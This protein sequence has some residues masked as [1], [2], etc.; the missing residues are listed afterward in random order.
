MADVIG[1]L[2]E[3]HL[4]ACLRTTPDPVALAERLFAWELDG[5]WDV[6]DQA[7]LRYAEVLGDTGLARYRGLAEEAW[8]EVPKLGPGENSQERY[9]SRFR[10]TRIMQSLAQLSGNLADRIAVEERDLSI[11]Y[12]FLQIAELCREH[13]EDDAALEWAERGMAAFAEDPDPR[14]RG[15]LV[16][17][18]RRRGRS[19]EALE[20]SLQ[21][22]SARPALET[23]RE[24]ATDAEG[25]GAVGGTPA[26]G[27]LAA[28][29]SGAG[30]A[31][32]GAA[33]LAAR[34]RLLAARAGAALGGRSRWC[35]GCGNGGRLQP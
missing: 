15:F 14:L 4:D 32:G 27:A 1:R 17:E 12:R 30:P 28:P 29:P 11:G 35:L 2:E 10:I 23:Y 24:L 9:G 7:V 8:S 21:A 6:F 20:H 5:A 26:L 31:G 18:Y 22:F 19:A 16:E 34:A 13:G 25:A 33:P 3:L